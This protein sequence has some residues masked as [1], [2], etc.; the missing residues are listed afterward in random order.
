MHGLTID[1]LGRREVVLA[2]G[3][4][5][6]ASADEHPDLFWALRGGGGNFGVVTEFEFRLHP[7]GPIVHL[8]DAVLRA[9]AGGRRAAR[10]PGRGRRPRRGT[11]GRRSSASTRRRRRSSRRSTTSRRCR[12]DPRRFRRRR[13]S[14]RRRRA[15]S[16]TALQPLFEVVTPMPYVALQQMLDEGNAL[17]NVRAYT[18][19]LYLD[20]LPDAAIDV[21]AER[22]PRAASPHVRGSDRSRSA[23]PSPTSP[24][25]R[26]R[27]AGSR[28]C[29]TWSPSSAWPATRRA[30]SRTGSGSATPGTPCGPPR[31]TTAGTST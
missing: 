3:R 11:T 2:D 9:G 23:R 29:G 4:C 7:V 13:R 10:R 22:L 27:S 8:G 17:G 12:A 16:A 25:T 21:L 14:T 24:T 15:G 19:G 20:E 26:R 18:K 5:V 30:S 1:N 31:R 28:R 6:R